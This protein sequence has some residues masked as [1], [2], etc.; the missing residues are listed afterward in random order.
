MCVCVCVPLRA[1]RSCASVLTPSRLLRCV[2]LCARAQERQ[3]FSPLENTTLQQQY[4]KLCDAV[5]KYDEWLRTEIARQRDLGN[6]V[7][8]FSAEAVELLEWLKDKQDFLN[9]SFAA[10]PKTDTTTNQRP[11]V[12]EKLPNLLVWR[13]PALRQLTLEPSSAQPWRVSSSAIAS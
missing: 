3:G 8:E 6:M 9:T 1:S 11:A 7:Q 5:A 10:A 12:A 4:Q 2:R 13:L